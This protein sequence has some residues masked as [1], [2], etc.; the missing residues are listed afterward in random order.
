MLVR[1]PPSTKTVGFWSA[2]LPT[3]FRIT[4]NIC[5]QR[6]KVTLIFMT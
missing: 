5:S 2:V 1:V 4:Y 3:V 6:L